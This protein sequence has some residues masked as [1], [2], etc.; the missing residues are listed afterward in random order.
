MKSYFKDSRYKWKIVL[1]GL[2]LALKLA[3]ALLDSPSSKP[4]S[5][6]HFEGSYEVDKGAKVV[7]DKH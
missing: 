7:L 4:P 3:S 2:L 6:Y 1:A 5:T